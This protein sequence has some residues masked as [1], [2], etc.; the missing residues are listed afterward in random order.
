MWPIISPQMYSHARH[1][2]AVL[3]LNFEMNIQRLFTRR[4]KR[5]RTPFLNTF[6]ARKIINIGQFGWY[7]R[8]EY[9]KLGRAKATT[10]F[11]VKLLWIIRSFYVS[12]FICTSR[13]TY[14]IP[15]VHIFLHVC[16]K[17]QFSGFLPKRTFV[18]AL[19]KPYANSNNFNGIRLLCGV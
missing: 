12:V 19:A 16:D 5:L 11:K 9:K 6:N 7:K 4:M 8:I 10:I 18:N 13:R 17:K 14:C 1:E 3:I 15:I 2:I